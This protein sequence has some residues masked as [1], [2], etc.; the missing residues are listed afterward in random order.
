M[1]CRGCRQE[2]GALAKLCAGRWWEQRE[3]HW[4]S[5][6]AQAAEAGR[7]HRRLKVHLH[8]CPGEADLASALS[9]QLLNSCKFWLNTTPQCKPF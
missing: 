9:I 2:G 4:Q 8:I 1:E 7:V 6:G 3:A 5:H